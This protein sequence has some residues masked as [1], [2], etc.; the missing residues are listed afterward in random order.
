MRTARSAGN[1]FGPGRHAYAFEQVHT[2]RSRAHL[3]IGCHDGAF[4][5]ALRPLGVRRLVGI[6]VDG[7]AVAR[8]REAHDGVELVQV[9]DTRQL[10]FDDASFDSLTLLDVLEHLPLDDQHAL[11]HEMRRVVR[12]TGVCVVTVPRRHALSVLDLGNLK[13][14]LPAL[15]RRWYTWRHGAEEYR[16]RYGENPF[17][18]VGDVSAEKRWHEHFT[19]QALVALL[20]EAGLASVDVDGSGLFMRLLIP[21]RLAA[22]SSARP[23]LSRLMDRDAARFASANLFVTAERTTQPQSSSP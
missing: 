15:H 11:L 16:V 7:A 1:P 17:G 14:R 19:A 6:E 10:P 9:A 3:D 22:P 20:A 13:F 8:G 5:A 12:P 23:S 21:A 4:L 2:A 18:L